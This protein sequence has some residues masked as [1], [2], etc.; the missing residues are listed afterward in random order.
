MSINYLV[1]K[2]YPKL[3][4]NDYRHLNA[5]VQRSLMTTSR[6]SLQLAADA[7][8]ITITT[9]M[10]RN[11]RSKSIETTSLNLMVA[12][13]IL[14]LFKCFLARVAIASF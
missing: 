12:G 3:F 5:I 6:R 8:T 11:A 13:K 10:Q 2:Q 4:Q 9:K 14:S 7:L 1:L